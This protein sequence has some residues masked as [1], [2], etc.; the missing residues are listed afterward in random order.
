MYAFQLQGQLHVFHDGSDIFA[1]KQGTRSN[2]IACLQKGGGRKTV[3]LVLH[4]VSSAM[5]VVVV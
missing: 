5:R 1:R 4:G 2:I 3:I